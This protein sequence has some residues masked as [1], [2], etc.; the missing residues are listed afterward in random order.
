MPDRVIDV[1]CLRQKLLLAFLA[2]LVLGCTT[3]SNDKSIHLTEH[4]SLNLTVPPAEKVG[5]IDSH[6]VEITAR[7]ESHRFIAQV[8][9]R[10]NEIA[11]ASISPSGVPLFD[12]IWFNDSAAEINQY[13]DLPFNDIRFIIADMQLCHWPINALKESLSG[14]NIRVVQGKNV[15]QPDVI[16]QRSIW[17]KGQL[18]I[19]IDKLQDGYQ[20]E[21]IERNYRIRLVNLNKESA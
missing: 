14:D 3:L 2:C 19:K 13:V 20:L 11:M 4:V 17:D 5:T 7:G 8:E 1:T 9:Y 21:N 18:I 6:L 12:F 15:S 10:A 16:W